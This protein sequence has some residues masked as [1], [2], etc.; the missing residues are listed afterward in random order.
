M[1]KYFLIFM[2]FCGTLYSASPQ[3]KAVNHY[4]KYN[5]YQGRSVP[6][7]GGWKFYDNRGIQQYRLTPNVTSPG[8]LNKFDNRNQYQGKQR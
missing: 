2:L 6:S 7:N 1:I 4:D 8:T 5:R 3:P